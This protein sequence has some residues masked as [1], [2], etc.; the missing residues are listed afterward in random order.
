MSAVDG[1]RD[2]VHMLCRIRC[3]DR[4]RLGQGGQVTG[5][6]RLGILLK[7]HAEGVRLVSVDAGDEAQ[8]A[9]SL[10]L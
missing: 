7:S 3:A 5:S 8:G 2:D 10:V 1:A 9:F 4:D 6:V